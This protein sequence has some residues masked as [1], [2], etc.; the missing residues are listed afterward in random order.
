VS[1]NVIMLTERG[2]SVTQAAGLCRS[3]RG[4][5]TQLFDTKTANNDEHTL[6][7]GCQFV[8]ID[9]NVLDSFSRID[10]YMLNIKPS[11][12]SDI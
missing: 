10:I 7:R 4:I 6:R 3:V 11:A 2:D 9:N 12:P 8:T 5:I 1:V